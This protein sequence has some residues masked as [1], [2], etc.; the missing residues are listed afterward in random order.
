MLEYTSCSHIAFAP[1]QDP[2]FDGRTM[3]V[4]PAV[5][6]KLSA[7]QK[8]YWEV[9]SQYMDVLLFFK[10]GTFYELYEE[11]AEVVHDVLDWKLTV[12]GVG[13]C[14]QAGCPEKGLPDAI[15][16]LTNAGMCLV[17]LI[18]SLERRPFL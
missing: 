6:N 8:Q 14:R 4:P 5:F 13:H 18:G 9:K 10:V 17:L 2:G 16:A 12:T 1:V 3:R 11:D 7:S 15:A